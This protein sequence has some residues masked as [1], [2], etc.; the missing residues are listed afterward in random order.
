MCW[1][2]RIFSQLLE[3]L[4]AFV[5]TVAGYSFILYFF[6]ML[7][8]LYTESPV[9]KKFIAE[10]VLLFN[11]INS[12]MNQNLFLFSFNTSLPTI[13]ICFIV[14][15]VCHICFLKRRFYDSCGL[16]GR[17]LYFGLPCSAV[18]AF[19]NQPLNWNL[20]FIV[21][22]LPTLALFSYCFNLASKLLP[23]TD[24]VFRYTLNLMQKISSM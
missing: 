24:D 5:I 22:L 3:F 14:A 4:L 23:E 10:N 15:V 19:Y 11:D 12:I 13:K 7:W 17:V 2:R 16:I 9:G 1:C 20:A 18:T 6:K 21:S 8:V